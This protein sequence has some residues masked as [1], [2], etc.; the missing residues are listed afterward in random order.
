MRIQHGLLL[1]QPKVRLAHGVRAHGLSPRHILPVLV[2]DRP[3]RDHVHAVHAQGGELL[4]DR[5]RQ[6]PHRRATSAVRR[7]A[8]VRPQRAQRARKDDG[9]FVGAALGEGLAT[10]VLEEQLEGF[11]GEGH[12]APGENCCESRGEKKKWGFGLLMSWLVLVLLLL[13][14]RGRR[15]RPLEAGELSN[16]TLQTIHVFLERLLLE[17]FYGR[18]LDAVYRHAEL[19]ILERG[20]LL[21]L[22]ECPREI[23]RRRV[24][25]ER[26]K[27]GSGGAGPQRF[28]ERCEIFRIACQEG[29]GVVAVRWVGEDAGDASA[30]G[31]RSVPTLSIV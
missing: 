8:R 26:L 30:L 3:V 18:V 12:C 28:G 10:V 24:G 11:V 25:G 17:R 13:L 5:L 19:E 2:P 16:F 20:M 21:D 7:E 1:R 15:G 22:L 6:A 4:R 29:D 27:D 9:A 14:R 31:R 23:R